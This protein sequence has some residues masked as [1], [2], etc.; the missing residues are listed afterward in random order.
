MSRQVDEILQLLTDASGDPQP[1][2]PSEITVLPIVAAGIL[3]DDDPDPAPPDVATY[4]ARARGVDLRIDVEEMTALKA[5][6][7]IFDQGVM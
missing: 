7:A 6:G 4:V 1:L 5:A 3:A 2:V